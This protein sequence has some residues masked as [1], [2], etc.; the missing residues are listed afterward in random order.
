MNNLE[1]TR[2]NLARR[3]IV[4]KIVLAAGYAGVKIGGVMSALGGGETAVGN[5]LRALA[6]AGRIESSH[7]TGAA[8]RWG[9]PGIRARFKAAKRKRKHVSRAE[10]RRQAAAVDSFDRPPTQLWIDARK[11]PPVLR[12]GMVSSVWGLGA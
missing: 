4:C 6:A 2:Q 10:L 7:K 11:A 8:C 5:H 1:S 3:E 12:A 9:P